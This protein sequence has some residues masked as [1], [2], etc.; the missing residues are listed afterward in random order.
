[1]APYQVNNVGR[2]PTG[3]WVQFLKFIVMRAELVKRHIACFPRMHTSSSSVQLVIKFQWNLNSRR[4]EMK[5]N[6]QCVYI[7]EVF[8]MCARWKKA[9]TQH[10]VELRKQAQRERREEHEKDLRQRKAL[11]SINICPMLLMAFCFYVKWI[12][13]WDREAKKLRDNE[14]RPPRSFK[15]RCRNDVAVGDAR[16]TQERKSFRLRT[17]RSRC[18][19]HWC[20]LQFE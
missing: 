6:A 12:W 8:D 13:N 16:D 3:T 5:C 2:H 10:L 14:A 9:T 11:E 15:L 7:W 18:E 19:L 20:S 17:V 4:A 1:M